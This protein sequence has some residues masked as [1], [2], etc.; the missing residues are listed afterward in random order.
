MR[1][2]PFRMVIS[3]RRSQCFAPPTP[4]RAIADS[5]PASRIAASVMEMTAR[6]NSE[7]PIAEG[8]WFAQPTDARQQIGIHEPK[9]AFI[10][11]YSFRSL[12]SISNLL[13][14]S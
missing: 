8:D 9:A 7:I 4:V 11:K 6:Y 12:F 3:V 14:Y 10:K 13:R 2:R 1:L 5:R